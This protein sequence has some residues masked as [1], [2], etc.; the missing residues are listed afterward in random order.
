MVIDPEEFRRVLGNFATGVTVVTVAGGEDPPTGI[1]VSAF[2]SV[3][4]DPPLVLVCIDRKA[5]THA[6][7]QRSGHFPVN[8]LASGQEDLSRRFASTRGD[9]FE[10]VAH[11]RGP[12][13]QPL[14]EGAVAV[15][16]CS[17]VSAHEHGDHTVFV[18]R[19]HHVQTAS[20]GPL[21]YFRG[22]YRQ[23]AG[24]SL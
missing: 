22:Q 3:S 13:G 9:K 8:V 4:L 14:L 10:G 20:A 24:G 2:A 7:L 18:G 17:T 1:T 5:Q 6:A 12:L 19:V 11:H 15:M 21:L 23:L 16:E